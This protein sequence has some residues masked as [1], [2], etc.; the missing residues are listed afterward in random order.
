MITFGYYLKRARERKTMTQEK[1]AKKIG[2]TIT[3]IQNWE[4]ETLPDKNHWRDIIR[5]YGL[6]GKEFSL[7][8]RSSILNESQSSLDCQFPLFLFP[9]C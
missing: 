3:T 7:N 6:N 8:L 5:V 9:D 4:K 2:V 1:A